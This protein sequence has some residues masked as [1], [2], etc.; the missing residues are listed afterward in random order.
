MLLA[1]CCLLPAACCLLAAPC[2][3]GSI[4]AG[5]ALGVCCCYIYICGW[6]WTP[7]LCIAWWADGRSAPLPH[8]TPPRLNQIG[9]KGAAALAEGLEAVPGLRVLDLQ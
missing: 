6:P 4:P 3:A 2:V 1:A 8:R 9:D 5:G 7:V